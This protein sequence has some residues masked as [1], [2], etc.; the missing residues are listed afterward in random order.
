MGGIKLV[1]KAEEVEELQSIELDET[2]VITEGI[3]LYTWFN[4]NWVNFTTGEQ[5]TSFKPPKNLQYFR[6]KIRYLHKTK[7]LQH[8]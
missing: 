8:E 3:T 4:D 6:K 7:I 2:V 5:F 1:K